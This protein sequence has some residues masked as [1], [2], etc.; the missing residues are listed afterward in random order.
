MT[1]TLSELF[2]QICVQESLLAVVLGLYGDSLSIRGGML[3]RSFGC[4]RVYTR[5]LYGSDMLGELSRFLIFVYLHIINH[6]NIFF[7]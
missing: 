4:F 3:L 5:T 1:E 2:G 7:T 6:F